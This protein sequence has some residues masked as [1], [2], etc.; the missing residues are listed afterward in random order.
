MF[1]NQHGLMSSNFS[2]SIEII[3]YIFKAQLTI[4]PSRTGKFKANKARKPCQKPVKKA[5]IESIMASIEA[6][7]SVAL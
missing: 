2:W 1:S 7:G 6:K 3:V 5:T 4:V